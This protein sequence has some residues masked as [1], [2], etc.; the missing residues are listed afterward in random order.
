MWDEVSLSIVHYGGGGVS[1]NKIP[2][3]QKKPYII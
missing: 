1:K 3:Q 2:E